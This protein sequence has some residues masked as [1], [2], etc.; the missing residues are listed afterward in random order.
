LIN[1]A[2]KL[3]SRWN[4]RDTVSLLCQANALDSMISSIKPNF[5]ALSFRGASS[6]VV[7]EVAD[8]RPDDTSTER[9]GYNLFLA[10]FSCWR[11]NSPFFELPE[12]LIGRNSQTLQK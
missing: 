1:F 5:S 3:F 11:W 10:L 12:T 9:G 2:I 4:T 6:I 7:A 8:P